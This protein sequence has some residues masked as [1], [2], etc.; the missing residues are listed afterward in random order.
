[1]KVL[2]IVFLIFYTSLFAQCDKVDT[3]HFNILGDKVFDK[4]TQLT[5]MRCSIGSKWKDNIGCHPSPNTISFY[6]AKDIENSL[7]NGWRIPT[8]EELNTIFIDQCEQYAINSKLFPDIKLLDNFAPYWSSTSVQQ[9]QNFIYYI[10]F[11]NK[12]LDAHSK[13]FSLFLRLVKSKKPIKK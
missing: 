6:E 7:N 2:L 3:S 11:I 4:K 1:M 8:I 10:D 5:W 13:G 9:I 12:R